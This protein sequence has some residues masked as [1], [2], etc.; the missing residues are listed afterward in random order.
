VAWR[1]VIGASLLTALLLMV[2]RNLLSLYLSYVAT[3]SAYGALGGV[4]G[5][6][7]WIY[8]TAAILLYGAELGSLYAERFGRRHPPFRTEP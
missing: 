4:L 6:M 8:G 2:M 1:D 5:L 7:T 3:Y